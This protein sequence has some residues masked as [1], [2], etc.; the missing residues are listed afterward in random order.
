MRAPQLVTDIKA[1]HDLPLWKH[2]NCIDHPIDCRLTRTSR[3]LAN[4]LGTTAR[5][6]YGLTFRKLLCREDPSIRELDGWLRLRHHNTTLPRTRGA[7]GPR[8]KR[9]D[10]IFGWGEASPNTQ[11]CPPSPCPL[12]G[13]G[14]GLG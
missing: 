5:L 13:M 11:Q 2:E 6:R 9:E 12:S 1:A 4:A 10:D 8:D 3:Q 14:R 7:M